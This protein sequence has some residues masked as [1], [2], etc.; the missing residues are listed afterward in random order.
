[1]APPFGRKEPIPMQTRANR[2]PESS[3]HVRVRRGIRAAARRRVLAAACASCL[4][5]QLLSGV[6]LAAQAPAAPAAARPV[7]GSAAQPA[8]HSAAHLRTR[9]HAKPSAAKLALQPVPAPAPAA[10]PAPVAPPLP[11]WPVNDQPAEATVVWDSR[12]LLIQATNSSLDQILKDVSLKTGAKVEGLGADQRIFGIYGPGPARDVLAQLLDGSGYN[13]L[14]IGDRGA[15]TPRRIVLSGRPT[16]PAPTP[17]NANANA[18]NDN[19]QGNMGNDQ[20]A[21][22]GVPPPESGIA[23]PMPVRPPQQIMEQRR[24]MELM[25]QQQR[26]NP[27]EP[28]N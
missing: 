21:E 1:M 3:R 14:M 27:Q 5:A 16:G 7:A 19:D 15:G 18:T 26:N 24:L 8:T 28:Q 23:P 20:E 12:G 22:Q 25:Q 2:R 11:H 17:G 13:I 4:A 9:A 10:P 6:A